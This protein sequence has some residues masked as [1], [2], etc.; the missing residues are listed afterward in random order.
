MTSAAIRIETVELDSA[1][2][3]QISARRRSTELLERR[4]T[5]IEA[6]IREAAEIVRKSLDSAPDAA[7]W[8]TTSVEASFGVTL[9]AETGVV[10]TKASAEASFMVKITVERH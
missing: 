1:G 2:S 5:E 3:R 9:A 4:R 7:Q 6:A 8:R 10:L